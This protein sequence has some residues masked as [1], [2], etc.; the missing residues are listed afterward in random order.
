VQPNTGL[1]Q[2]LQGL[3]MTKPSAFD[4]KQIQTAVLGEK[5]SILDELHL[6]PEVASFIRN[7]S[8]TLI[9]V[10]LCMVLMILGWTFYKNYTKSRNDKAA[11]ALV[12]AMQVTEE[13]KRIQEIDRV[14]TE[15]SGTDA[16]H[17]GRLELAHID[18]QSNNFESAA[19]KYKAV[20]DDLSAD[21][22]LVPL[23]IYSIGQAYEQL[24]DV[25]SA[26][27]YYQTLA[28]TPGFAGEGYLGLGRLYEEK[29][30]LEKAR[31][32]YEKYLTLLNEKASTNQTGQTRNMVEDKLATLKTGTGAKET[33]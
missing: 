8:K 31:E 16:A 23:V 22:G 6:P 9:V 14:V 7:N 33:E 1:N 17:W 12:A 19:M 30:E 13:A 32:V 4:K 2:Q 18:Y 3:N 26:I 5:R 24:Q 20:L 29:E 27:E 28:K 15:F 10:A 25:D 11:A 21:S